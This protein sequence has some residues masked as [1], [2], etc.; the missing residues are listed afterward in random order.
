MPDST[1]SLAACG[2]ERRELPL[3]NLTV[4][5]CFKNCRVALD[6]MRME[7]TRL[8]WEITG[9]SILPSVQNVNKKHYAKL[10]FFAHV[11]KMG[12]FLHEAGC[13]VKKIG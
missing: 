11:K 5:F 9:F 3:E 6:E 1:R 2:R 10:C 8:V 13:H 4:R 7:A 12:I